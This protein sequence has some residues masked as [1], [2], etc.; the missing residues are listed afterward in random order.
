MNKKEDITMKNGET[1][2]L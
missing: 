1:R 2:K